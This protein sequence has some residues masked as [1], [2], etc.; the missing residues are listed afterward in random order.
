MRVDGVA[1][2]CRGLGH[3]SGEGSGGA[4]L[5]CIVLG[6]P[7]RKGGR[8]LQHSKTAVQSGLQRGLVG[9]IATNLHGGGFVDEAL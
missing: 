8:G 1:E 5:F 9:G 4:S 7:F 6:S 2:A 3:G